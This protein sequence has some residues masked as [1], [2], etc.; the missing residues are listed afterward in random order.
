VPRTVPPDPSGF[1]PKRSATAQWCQLDKMLAP[2]PLVLVIE[3]HKDTREM[4]GFFLQASGFNVELIEDGNVGLTKVLELRPMAIIVD[5]GI[6]GLNGWSVCRQLKSDPRTA[7]IALIVVT[8]HVTDEDQQ[9][10]IACGADA[11]LRKPV[12]LECLVAEI[13][14]LICAA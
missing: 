14:K 2:R 4:Y 8:G 7:Q 11:F 6:P 5:L 1:G 9:R 12:V 13:R 10:A 3:N